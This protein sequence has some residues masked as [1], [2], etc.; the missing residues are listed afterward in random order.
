[1][2]ELHCMRE[3]VHKKGANLELIVLPAILGL[4]GKLMFRVWKIMIDGSPKDQ[5]D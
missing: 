5:G 4:T 3:A 1:M 2:P